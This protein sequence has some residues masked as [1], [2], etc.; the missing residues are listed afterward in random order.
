MKQLVL[1]VKKTLQCF[2]Q[3]KATRLAGSIA[4]ATMFS[5]APIFIILVAILGFIIGTQNGGHGYHVAENMLLKAIQV[6]AGADA[7]N[8]VRSMIAAQF[9]KPRQSIVAQII[10]WI[11]FALAAS[12]LFAA[13]EDAL[14]AVWNVESTKGGWKQLLRD[15]L[16]SFGMI[17][18]LG[19]VSL[20]FFGANTVASALSAHYFARI[21]I[22][23]SPTALQ[24]VNVVL[25]LVVVSFT[26]AALFKV[27]PAVD[28]RWHDVWAG[29]VATAVLFVI[30]EALI[31]LYIDKAAV[32]SAYGAAG[33]VLVALL[34]I[35]YSAIILLLGAEFTKVRASGAKTV[36]PSTIRSRVDVP[37][38]VD[39]RENPSAAP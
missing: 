15:R 30:G 11:A 38:G 34:W 20:V 6:R 10:G 29:G 13:I 9:S 18:V 31:S 5:M 22:V 21:A 14:N 26:F 37:A 16:A 1:D 28:I 17:A 36:A 35:Y 3:D 2:G 12:G 25:S 33:S 32:S 4:Y 27:L 23:N 8:T 39:P 19:F 24:V 7:T